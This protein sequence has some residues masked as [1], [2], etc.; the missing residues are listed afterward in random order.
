MHSI[1]VD[2]DTVW[3][4]LHLFRF[5]I[6]QL[7]LKKSTAR[8]NLFV[9]GVPYTGFQFDDLQAHMDSSIE[10]QKK[11]HVPR[12]RDREWQHASEGIA[13]YRGMSG[14]ASDEDVTNQARIMVIQAKIG[15]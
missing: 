10:W 3:F 5:M 13:V 4:Y 2:R 9:V 15:E 8:V 6:G 1:A 7:Q 12:A 14:T 11:R